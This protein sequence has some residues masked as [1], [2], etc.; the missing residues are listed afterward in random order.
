MFKWLKRKFLKIFGD[1]KIFKY[2]M[3]IVYD[4]SIYELEGDISTTR[5]GISYLENIHIQ[6]FI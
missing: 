3:W 2:P 1:I 4:P 5:M 6:E